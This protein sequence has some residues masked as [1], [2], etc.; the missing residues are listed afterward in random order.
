[1]TASGSIAMDLNNAT[2]RFME[3]T[4]P[5]L[6]RSIEKLTSK[7]DDAFMVDKAGEKLDAAIADLEGEDKIDDLRHYI[8]E[9]VRD[10]NSMYE[11]GPGE[12]P[13]GEA[14]D[15]L[16]GVFAILG[17]PKYESEAKRI[18]EDEAAGYGDSQIR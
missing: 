4:V 14:R 12:V 11:E 13:I 16:L 5:N 18:S 17:V 10:W 6:T 8:W 3:G 15:T 7:L 9:S 1:M 2:L